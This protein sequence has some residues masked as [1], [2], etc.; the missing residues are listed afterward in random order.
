M[1][2]IVSMSIFVDPSRGGLS[3][4]GELERWYTDRIHRLPLRRKTNPGELPPGHDRAS[5]LAGR[6]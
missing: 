6:R 4:R 3:L 1:N 5:L 2:V